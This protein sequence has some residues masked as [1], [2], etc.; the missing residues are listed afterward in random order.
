MRTIERYKLINPGDKILIAVSG[1]KDSL[2]LLHILSELRKKYNFYLK[3]VTI[4]LGIGDYSKRYIEKV[5]ENYE[6]LKV[7]Y[8]IVNVKDEIGLTISDAVK[9][10]RRRAPCSICGTIKRYVLNKVAYEWKFDKLA[11]GHNL[12]DI[13]SVLLRSYVRGDY[14]QALKLYPLLPGRDKLVTKIR[15][16]AE[17]PESDIALYGK[18]KGI[19]FLEEKCPYSVNS[20]GLV[21]REMLDILERESPSSKLSMLRSFYNVYMP[22]LESYYS[23]KSAELK[24]CKYCGMPASDDTCS[25]CKIVARVRKY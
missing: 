10:I 14:Q 20:K 17:T 8:E 2:V 5:E 13:L 7:E 4:D 23:E 3:G 16:L 6:E 1:G 19:N 12:D 25:V 11:T 22:A 24:Y 21:H 15:P 9:G 18:I